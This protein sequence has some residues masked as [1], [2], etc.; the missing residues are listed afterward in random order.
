M[1]VMVMKEACKLLDVGDVMKAYGYLHDKFVYESVLVKALRELYECADRERLT[2]YLVVDACRGGWEVLSS[3]PKGCEPL[4]E[5]RKNPRGL[6]R[7][8]VAVAGEGCGTWV[9]KSDGN[10]D[11]M[12]DTVYYWMDELLEALGIL[13]YQKGIDLKDGEQESELFEVLGGL[14]CQE[15]LSRKELG[16]SQGSFG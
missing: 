12:V 9:S 2:Y 7:R 3:V 13:G 4:G 1:S 8:V 5:E 15:G 10:F 16:S 6:L 11:G 14:D